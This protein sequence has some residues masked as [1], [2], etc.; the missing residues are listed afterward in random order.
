MK[1]TSNE[2]NFVK[3][4]RVIFYKL[5]NKNLIV[6]FALILLL[7]S[8]SDDAYAQ[9]KG[10]KEAAQGLIKLLGEGKFGAMLT[11]VTAALAIVAAVAGS[12]KG[13]WAV[14][15]VSVGSFILKGLVQVFFPTFN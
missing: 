6:T 14:L 7:A 11:A 15:F 1:I 12:Y 5:E 2:I 13:A 8:T 10:F 9:G 4:L 3:K